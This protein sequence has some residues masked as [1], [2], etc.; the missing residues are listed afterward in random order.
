MMGGLVAAAQD[1]WTVVVVE[2][3]LLSFLSFLFGCT[4]QSD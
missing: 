4:S 2:L 3:W 1:G